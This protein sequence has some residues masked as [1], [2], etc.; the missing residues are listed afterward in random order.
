MEDYA[1]VYFGSAMF[2][3]IKLLFLAIFSVHIFACIFYRVKDISAASRGDVVDF[4]A[5]KDVAEDVRTTVSKAESYFPFT[6]RQ[7]WHFWSEFCFHEW[8]DVSN[9][10]VSEYLLPTLQASIQAEELKH[11]RF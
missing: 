2:K 4:Y 10:Y 8:Q 9:Q 3:I 1:V 5:S 7:P 6:L 11:L